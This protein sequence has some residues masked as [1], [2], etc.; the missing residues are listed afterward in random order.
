MQNNKTNKDYKEI[1]LKPLRVKEKNKQD[2]QKIIN[3]AT[4]SS[5]TA[6]FSRRIGAI[7][8]N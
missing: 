2:H 8:I 7:S 4:I 3:Q 6:N 1:E 5:Y